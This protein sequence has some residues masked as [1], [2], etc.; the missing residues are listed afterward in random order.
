MRAAVLTS[1]DSPLAVEKLQE[2]PLG[3]HDVRVDIQASGLCHSDLSVVNGLLPV[4]L[5]M[6]LGHEGAGTVVEVGADVHEVAVG[7]RVVLSFVPQCGACWFCVNGEPH[8]CEGAA[9][10]RAAVR[11]IRED[12]S[13][14]TGM[15][16]L[17]T[18]SDLLTT[19]VSSV[20]KLDT[21][22]PAE[23]LALLGCAVT[24]GV[25]AVLNTAAVPPGANV[26]VIGCGG[27]GQSVIQGAHLVGAA[28]IIAIDPVALKREVAARLGAT[29]VVDPADGD[30]V[31]QVKALTGGRGVDYAF[32][33]IGLPDTML[34]A[35]GMA[36]RG[37]AVVVVGMAAA[38]ATVTFRAIQLFVEG[39]RILGCYFGSTHVRRDVPRLVE[40]IEAGR[41]DIESM[42]SRRISLDEVDEGFRAMAAGEVIRTVIV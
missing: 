42:V 11:G 1:F 36:R 21:D 12:G 6:I 35:F 19:E 32:E 24:T 22:L 4:Q 23:Q 10:T 18:F 25:G 29:H 27:V 26:A 20:V 39:K 37:G 7:D 33:A 8:L 40:L 28:R 15:A 13:T 41:L 9:G 14:A 5:P 34:Q 16:G 3:R 30:V 17:G 38:A 31:E 2:P